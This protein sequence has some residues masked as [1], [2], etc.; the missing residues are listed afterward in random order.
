MPDSST[1]ITQLMAFLEE[2]KDIDVIRKVFKENDIQ[3]TEIVK[4]GIKE[5]IELFLHQ[6]SPQ[7]LVIDISKS[8]LPLSDLARFSEVCEPGTSL[9][10]VGHKNDVG[11]YRDLMKIG[12][13]EYVVS[14]LL[15]EIIGRALKNMILGEEKG[16]ESLSRF[17]K[18]IAVVGSRG[19][20][21]ST[22]I[23]TNIATILSVEKLRRIA[24]VDFDLHFGTVT[25]NLD[26]K[27]SYGLR[28]A[29][30]EP[31]RV[32]QVFLERLLIPVNEH[33][34]ALDS[35][36]PLDEPLKYS[37]DA[38][39]N[40]LKNLS[41]LFH[42]VIVDL[43]HYSDESTLTVLAN[44][45]IMILVTDPSLA[46]LRDSGRLLRLF[47]GEGVDHRSI[48]VINK[49]G[50]FQKGEVSIP[51][52]EEALKVKI[53]H[54]LPYD[55]LIPMEYVNR[56]KTLA[57]QVNPLASGIRKIANDVQGIKEVEKQQSGLERF[58][59]SIKLK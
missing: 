46:G 59:Q 44:A 43:P 21:G 56:G 22:F 42:Y 30:E 3:N 37:A 47:G 1:G 34:Y 54:I 58:L 31:D 11:L 52:F 57:D 13:F 51:D 27:P 23:A 12:I 40:L 45:K 50:A 35:E 16:K 18:I 17:G 32:D 4:G 5:A 28:N 14:P 9:I 53:E 15:P 26:L 8:D 7:Y 6:R 24:I 41:K 20:V 49:F 10:A 36:E 33:L 2:K 19:G 48:C 29:L 55:S 38:I 25:L 39:E